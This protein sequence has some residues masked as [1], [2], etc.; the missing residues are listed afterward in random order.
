MN[1]PTA[2]EVLNATME[3]H[4][5][6]AEPLTLDSTDGIRRTLQAQGRA[7]AALA[8]YIDGKMPDEMMVSVNGKDQPAQDKRT[9]K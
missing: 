8:D 9:N 3:D 7:I 2:H 5:W 1:K 4:A 6:K